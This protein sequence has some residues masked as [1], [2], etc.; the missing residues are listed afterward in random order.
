MV[1]KRFDNVDLQCWEYTAE[2]LGIKPPFI[3]LKAGPEACEVVLS[4]LNELAGLQPPAQRTMTLKPSQRPKCCTKI[5]FAISY[6]SDQ[7]TEMWLTRSGP[8]ANFEFTAPGLQRFRDAV[9]LWKRGGED[10]SVHPEKYSD[11][12]KDKQSGEVWF[13]TPFTDP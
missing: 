12:L 11:G 9:V 5:R 7:L 1:H 10:F 2:K 13:W 3:C 6:R 8:L 4:M